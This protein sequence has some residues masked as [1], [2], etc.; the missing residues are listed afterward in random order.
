MR[1]KY[2]IIITTL[3]FASTANA[4]YKD[5]KPY[6]K[7]SII[8]PT[9]LKPPFPVG[10]NRYNQEIKDIIKMQEN[11]NWDEVDAAFRERHFR[12]FMM[13]QDVIPKL[14]RI[15]YPK[16]YH[17]LDRIHV[18]SKGVSNSAKKFWAMKRPYLASKDI[19]P[20]IAAHTSPAYPSGH[21]TVSYT[22]AHIMS[23][24]F[25]NKREEFMARAEEI[26]QHRILVGMHFPKDIYGGRHLALLVVGALMDNKEFQKDFIKAKK[27]ILKNSIN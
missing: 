2:L 26:A 21:T 18:T 9:L 15:K 13:A 23:Q 22:M 1:L 5:I 20:L 14:E 19:D 24:I 12:P 4:K 10:S 25:P 3:I 27:E 16:L 17:L 7:G 6:F 8:S 11:P